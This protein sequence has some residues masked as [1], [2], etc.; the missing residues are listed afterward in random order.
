V[1]ECRL[2]STQT[3]LRFYFARGYRDDGP[4]AT[5]PSGVTALPMRKALRRSG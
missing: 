5:S 1:H 4:P 2:T 3:A